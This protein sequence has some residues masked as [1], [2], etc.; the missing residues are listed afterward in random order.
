MLEKTVGVG[1][2]KN[3]RRA[4]MLE[5]AA[6]FLGATALLAGVLSPLLACK[7]KQEGACAAA[8][9]CPVGQVCTNGACVVAAAPEPAPAPAPAPKAEPKVPEKTCA[10]VAISGEDRI[11]TVSAARKCDIEISDGGDTLKST[12][13]LLLHATDKRTGKSKSHGGGTVIINLEK[14]AQDG[15]LT[16][17]KGTSRPVKGGASSSVLLKF[18]KLY[19]TANGQISKGGSP[20][21]FTFRPCK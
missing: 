11:Q 10:L 9:D 18:S 5:R 13:S 17:Y 12:C 6:R 20:M 19:D 3:A 15:K 14:S 1:C 4:G 7:Q 21:T 16:T 8:T 2:G